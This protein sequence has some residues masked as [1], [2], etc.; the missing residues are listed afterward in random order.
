MGGFILLKTGCQDFFE[1]AF[2]SG[3]L[4]VQEKPEPADVFIIAVPTP[5]LEDK[6]A[7]MRYVKSAAK[8]I[9]PYLDKGNLV[10]LEST[11]PPMT[12]LELVL[13]ILEQTGLEVGKDLI[14]AYSPE[15]VLPGRILRE[16][17]ENARVVG[18][19]DQKS[20]RACMD[21]YQTFVKGEII[22]TDSTTAE[23]VKLMENTYRDVNIAIA[24]EFSRLSNL[25]HVDVREA[26]QIANLHPRVNILKPG[27]GVGGH[28]ISVEPWFLVEKAPELSKLIHAARL[29]N[30]SQP[31]FVVEKVREILGDVSDKKIGVLGLSYKPDVDDIRESP[32]IKVVELLNSLGAEVKAFEPFC[33]NRIEGINS[34]NEINDAIKGVDLVLV[35]VGH[36]QFKELD[37]NLFPKNDGRLVLDTMNIIPPSWKNAGY[38]VYHLGNGH[39][40]SS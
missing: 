10:V 40:F 26:I 33:S 12:T 23:L 5:I 11:S 8:S 39:E 32:A 25:F 4:V 19:F 36:S 9:L 7:D 21:L 20:A 29:V 30:D 35:L 17:V 14:L 34:V 3:N 13:P 28:C 27:P 22:L 2:H 38:K 15:R 16:L 31:A 37:P 1:S 6:K 24:N 18:G